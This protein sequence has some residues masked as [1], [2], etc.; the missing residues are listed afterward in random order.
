M[1]IMANPD[2]HDETYQRDN[3]NQGD[4]ALSIMT[5]II[6]MAMI[7]FTITMMIINDHHLC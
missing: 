7:T 1:T 2:N 6:T 4:R 3:H 5:I